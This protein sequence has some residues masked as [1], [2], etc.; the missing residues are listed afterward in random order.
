[1]FIAHSAKPLAVEQELDYQLRRLRSFDDT[2]QFNGNFLFCLGQLYVIGKAVI[3][4]IL[5]GAGRPEYNKDRA[6]KVMGR[7]H[8]ELHA[9]LQRVA[10]LKPFYLQVTRR[11]KAP[12]PFSYRDADNHV[13]G[14]ISAIRR[15][16]RSR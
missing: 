5:A 1:M 14:T 6:F 8:P 10:E 13:A 12:F 4:V 15:I 7:T 11:V 9:D 2:S 16:A 3:M